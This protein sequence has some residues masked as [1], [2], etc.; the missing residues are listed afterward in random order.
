M[1]AGHNDEI[2]N[3]LTIDSRPGSI[4]LIFAGDAAVHL[5][6]EAIRCHLEDIGQPWPTPWRPHPAFAAAAR[7]PSPPLAPPGKQ[8]WPLPGKVAITGTERKSVVA[9][10]SV[11][12]RV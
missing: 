3:L 12:V 7:P 5:E 1:E 11:N 6:V 9:G 10:R 8:A 4:T 2:L